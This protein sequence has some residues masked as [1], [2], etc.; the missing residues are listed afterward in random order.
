MSA[1]QLKALASLA[2][3]LS[4]T[5]WAAEQLQE[6]A[7]FGKSLSIPRNDDVINADASLVLAYW[8]VLSMFDPARY[9]QY[10]NSFVYL[11]QDAQSRL[12]DTFD[13]PIAEVRAQAFAIAQFLAFEIARYKGPSP[14][15]RLDR[16]LRIELIA[17]SGQECRC[18]Y[19]GY[20]FDGEVM[21]A[22]IQ[23][24]RLDLRPALYVDFVTPRGLHAE[25]SRIE[26]DHI[27]PLAA[28]GSNE[29]S[30]MRIACGWCNR[31]KS[32]LRLLFEA[33]KSMRAI[34]HPGLGAVSIPAA[35][36]SI[37]VRSV[38]R[39]CE[40]PDGCAARLSN[41][42]LVVGPWHREGAMVPGNLAVFCETHDPLRDHRLVAARY[43]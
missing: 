9:I 20:R 22:F 23:A 41:T 37:R 35:F 30:N 5:P 26:V 13:V 40:Y 36:W 28:G 14:R 43:C 15:N 10:N 3:A 4:A 17:S 27:Q 24:R 21:D 8:N 11:Y 39:R 25:D 18:W 34:D 16:S 38:R 33:T 19:C 7:I 29:L 2:P 6:V 32:S 31:G 1:V 12:A 42:E